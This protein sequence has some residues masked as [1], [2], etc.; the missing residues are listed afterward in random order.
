MDENSAKDENENYSQRDDD[1][2]TPEDK[3]MREVRYEITEASNF[4]KTRALFIANI[5]DS[6]DIDE[7]RNI[8]VEEARRENCTIERAWLN[9][10]RSHCY[11][12]CSDTPGAVAIQAKLNGFNFAE[13]SNVSAEKADSQNR[14]F[15][16]FVPVRAIESWIEQEKEGPPDA[17]WKITYVDK[18]SKEKI[19]TFFKLVIHEMVN[20]PN[21]SLGYIRVQRNN[22]STNKSTRANEII[23]V[24]TYVPDRV[25]P[26]ARRIGSIDRL[27]GRDRSRYGPKLYKPAHTFRPRTS[28][29]YIPNYGNR[30]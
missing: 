30:R 14:L 3:T 21:A 19:G 9:S 16:D 8:M 10:S 28:D 25:R 18:P 7:F 27:R 29:T 12:L 24:S 6:L 11:V 2:R 23:G 22:R 20:Y 13:D 15:A 26:P 5:T 1:S 4:N 17:I